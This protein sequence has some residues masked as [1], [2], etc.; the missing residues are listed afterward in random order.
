MTADLGL[1]ANTAIGGA[2]ALSNI[3]HRELKSN[4]NRHF[5]TSEI[6]AL[7]AEYQKKRYATTKEL[8]DISGMMTRMHSYGSLG[9]R[10]FISYIAP[11]LEKKNTMEFVKLMAN[12]PKL[13]YAPL[14]TMNEDAEGWKLANKKGNEKQSAGVLTY[15]LITSAVGILI[16]YATIRGW[17]HDGFPGLRIS[18]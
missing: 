6:S 18:T 17:N 2:V 15:F 11:L 4:Q 14:R 16:S 1:G 9:K 10:L 12:Q 8:V 7:F 3:L 5:T 13:D